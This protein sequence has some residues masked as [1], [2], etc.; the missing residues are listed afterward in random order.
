MDDFQDTLP[1]TEPRRRIWPTTS[2]EW[3]EL[4]IL[5]I[6]TLVVLALWLDLFQ[7]NQ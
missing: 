5:A 2:D 7:L 3:A 1:D 6:C 4:V